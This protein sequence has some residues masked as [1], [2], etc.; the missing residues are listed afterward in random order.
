[1]NTIHVPQAGTCTKCGEILRTLKIPVAYGLPMTVADLY[2]IRHEIV[3]AFCFVLE[4][5]EA[6]AQRSLQ[7]KGESR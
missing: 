7:P 2:Q 4:F 3:C 6:L 1:M 5:T